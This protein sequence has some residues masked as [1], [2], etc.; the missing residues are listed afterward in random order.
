LTSLNALS[1]ALPDQHPLER[2]DLHRLEAAAKELDAHIQQRKR[3]F[4]PS[5]PRRIIG[6]VISVLLISIGLAIATHAI[7]NVE[8]HFMKLML[9][10]GSLVIVGIMWIYSDWFE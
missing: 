2:H 5:T 1:T 9:V 8:K 4:R 7:T 10:S 6:L 3:I